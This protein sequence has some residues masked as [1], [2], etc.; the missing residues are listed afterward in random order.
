MSEPVYAGQVEIVRPA[1]P[2]PRS[3]PKSEVRTDDRIFS[4]LCERVDTAENLAELNAIAKDANRAARAK[5]LAPA[6]WEALKNAVLR[7]RGLIGGASAAPPKSEPAIDDAEID[8]AEAEAR[9]LD[10]VGGES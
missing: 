10:M 8:R 9:G 3:E 1:P 7:K 2:A 4:D 5:Q 6:E